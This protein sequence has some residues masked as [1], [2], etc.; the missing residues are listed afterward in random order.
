[1]FTTYLN[2]DIP[3]VSAQTKNRYLNNDIPI[4]SAQ[5]KNSFQ[6]YLNTYWSRS[7]WQTTFTAET[8]FLVPEQDRRNPLLLTDNITERQLR[9]IVQGEN[10]NHLNKSIALQ[11]RTLIGRTLPRHSHDTVH[12]ATK[13]TTCQNQVNTSNC[14]LQ[15]CI[16]K[17]LILVKAGKVNL[18]SNWERHGWAF[19]SSENK[20][21]VEIILTM[22]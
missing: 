12:G 5:T 1:M 7:A 18:I 6:D 21:N 8:A 14:K 4:V 11:V 16:A 17:R 2:N 3:I 19:V 13:L 22:H 20:N 10:A 15:K 9:L